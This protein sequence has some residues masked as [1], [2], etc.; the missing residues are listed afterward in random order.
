MTWKYHI[1]ESITGRYDMILGRDLLT[2]LGPDLKFSE[3]V[4]RGGE[5]PHKGCLA[6]MFDV[7][8]YDF[9]IVTAETV[10]R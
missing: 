9:N 5:G 10:K 8:T 6:P 3:N 2:A 1:Y 7:K 4:I